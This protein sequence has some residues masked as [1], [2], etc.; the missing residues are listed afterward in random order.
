MEHAVS[1]ISPEAL[2]EVKVA[3]KK[4]LTEIEKH[5]GA[6]GNVLLAETFVRWLETGSDVG[7]MMMFHRR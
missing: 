7:S 5:H 3:L 6:K 2:E 4:Y 1:Q